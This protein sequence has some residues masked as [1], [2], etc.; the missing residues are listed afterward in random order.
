MSKPYVSRGQSPGHVPIGQSA[1][2]AYPG[3]VSILGGLEVICGPMFSGKTDELIRRFMAADGDLSVV[4]LKPSRDTRH[5]ADAIVSHSAKQIPA[6]A[7]ESASEITQIAASSALVL[8]DE[9][10]FFDESLSVVIEGLRAVQADVIAAGLDYD[11]RGNPFAT[12]RKVISS[13][14]VVTRLAAVCGR[15]QSPATLTQ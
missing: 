9:I 4:A 3:S 5:Q 7:V 13:A 10:Q 12:T 15:C 14:S 11:F 6:T 1:R 8:I 2:R